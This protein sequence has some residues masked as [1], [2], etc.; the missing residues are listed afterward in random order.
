MTPNLGQGGCQALEDAA[1]IARLAAGTEPGEV[2]GMLA[3]YTALRL[4]RANNIVRWSRRAGIT[5]TWTSP[6]A[7]ALR[8]NLARL[9]GKLPPGVTARSLVPIYG[10]RPPGAA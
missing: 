1:V 3:R 8:D 6:L 2:P 4:P 9:A 10:W 7:V 5:A